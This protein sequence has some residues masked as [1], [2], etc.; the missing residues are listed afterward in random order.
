M[1]LNSRRS[2]SNSSHRS[3]NSS[4]LRSSNSSRLR[5]SNTSRRSSNS[6]RLRS[7]NTSR[8]KK[9][10]SRSR[11]RDINSRG[12]QIKIVKSAKQKIVLPPSPNIELISSDTETLRYA[13]IERQISQLDS[14]QDEI[15][16]ELHG[17]NNIILLCYN[18]DL[19]MSVLLFNI[20]NNNHI[21]I[22][23]LIT[24]KAHRGKKYA[25]KM[26]RI[27]NNIA[28]Y[29][30]ITHISLTSTQSSHG[31][32]LIMKQTILNNVNVEITQSGSVDEQLFDE[33]LNRCLNKG[34]IK[35]NKKR[36]GKG[37]Q[38]NEN[39]SRHKTKQKIPTTWLNEDSYN[40]L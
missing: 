9:N 5:S 24:H 22:M 37:F 13:R 21:I 19:L 39:Q 31:F 14:N 28:V 6:S 7:S 2:S 3:S 33:E 35:L 12:E 26:I 40:A 4:R 15:M 16:G 34:A 36:I 29:N 23:G 32:W 38:D 20:Q 18:N 25:S 27:L 30:N 10:R 11:S 17:A 1:Y 8:R